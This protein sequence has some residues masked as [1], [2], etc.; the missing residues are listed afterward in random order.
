MTLYDLK[1][2][3]TI[4]GN[5]EIRVYDPDT[6]AYPIAYYRFIGLADLSYERECDGVDC[7]ADKPIT[8]FDDDT[9]DWGEVTFI[10]SEEIDGMAFIVIEI[11]KPDEE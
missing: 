10:Y 7:I 11:E 4:Q 8:E 6:S 5:V 1:N 2:T 9:L 3:T